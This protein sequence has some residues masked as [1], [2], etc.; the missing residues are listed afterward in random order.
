MGYFAVLRPDDAAAELD[1]EVTRCHINLWVLPSFIPGRRLM[2]FDLGMEVT[3][4]GAAPVDAV[5]VLLPFTVETGYRMDQFRGCAD[6][7]DRLFDD[8][9]AELIFGEPVNLSGPA[10]ERTLTVEAGQYTYRP[11]RIDTANVEAANDQPP[12]SSCYRVPL[13]SSV[14]PGTSAYIR[15]RF[16]VF[17]NRPVLSAKSPFGGVILDFRIADVRESRT[18]SR[19]VGIRKRIV[20]IASVNFF[21]MLPSQ[22]QMI[23]ASPYQRYMRVLETRAW[24]KY[25]GGVAY[26]H[27]SNAQLVYY[28]R[29]EKRDDGTYL[30]VTADN[31]FRVFAN[32]DRHLN[33][34][35][36]LFWALMALLIIMMVARSHWIPA[37]SWTNAKW[38]LSHAGSFLGL[39]TLTGIIAFGKGAYNLVMNRVAKPRLWFRWIERILLGL[40]ADN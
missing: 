15:L 31:P 6:L 16:R 5:E 35:K 7:Y 37:L 22:Y 20:P 1:F 21:A 23:T 19:E 9:T 30:P 4:T 2:Y 10:T 24:S 32:Y 11:R 40:R 25:L 34:A 8:E 39:L 28:W 29:S 26:R 14:A 18:R 13:Q 38:V 3:A 33:K 12:R 17:G 36:T 27:P